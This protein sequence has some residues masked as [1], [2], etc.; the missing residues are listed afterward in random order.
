[1]NDELALADSRVEMTSF[2][3]LERAFC[4][5]SELYEDGIC[6]CGF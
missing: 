6:R 5:C 1:M 4:G 3:L 2:L